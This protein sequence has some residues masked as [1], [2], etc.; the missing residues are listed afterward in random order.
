LFVIL[1]NPAICFATDYPDTP[2]P[3]NVCEQVVK[4]YEDA[5]EKMKLC[6][7]AYASAPSRKSEPS[8]RLF[9]QA[10]SA[11]ALA[12]SQKPEL[13]ICYQLPTDCLKEIQAYD[14]NGLM[15]HVRASSMRL[16][17][18]VNCFLTHKEYEH[19]LVKQTHSALTRE[20][21]VERAKEYLKIFKIEVPPDYKLLEA[22]F[23]GDRPGR[24]HVLWRR[25]SGPYPWDGRSLNWECVFVDFYEKEG[26][27]VVSAN[28]CNCP[29]P[30]SLK[31]KVSKEE[32]IAKATRYLN[33]TWYNRVDGCVGKTVVTEVGT[34]ELLV[35]APRLGV[36]AEGDRQSDGQPPRETRLCWKTQLG[37]LSTSDYKNKKGPGSKHGAEV[38]VWIDAE[39]GKVMREEVQIS[40]PQ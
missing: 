24:W 14:P 39:T 16:V 37:T 36:L 20:A 40:F 27:V 25:F 28:G 17:G 7:P 6:S 11:Y 38:L 21:A 5:S 22:D 29:A 30:R 8:H 4:L 35:S 3:K 33:R 32:A 26:L 9:N 31:V 10:G 1:V 2:V 12:P 23:G 34:C 18:V 13:M 19:S 15:M